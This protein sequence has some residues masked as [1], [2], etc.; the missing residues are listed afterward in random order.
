MGGKR[1]RPNASVLSGIFSIL[2]QFRKLF[3]GNI[4][5]P[6]KNK[7]HDRLR[8]FA[9]ISILHVIVTSSRIYRV[10][11]LS[12]HHCFWLKI[13]ATRRFRTFRTIPILMGYRRG[14]NLKNVFFT[15]AK[16]AYAVRD[17][18]S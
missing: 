17:T 5:G 18:T 10:Y 4:L 7:R 12:I 6:R 8:F 9:L 13:S 15:R 16:T 1:Q 11:M 3:H 14:H 2:V